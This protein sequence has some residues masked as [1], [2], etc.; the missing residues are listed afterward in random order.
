MKLRSLIFWIVLPGALSA[1]PYVQ[2]PGYCYPPG[3]P[4]VDEGSLQTLQIT[5]GQEYTRYFNEAQKY[6]FCLDETK[7]LF[8]QEVQTYLE[9]Y[10][11][12]IQD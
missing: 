6:M 1:Q 3:P 10:T 5:R 11:E 4:L 2:M 7:K 8:S 12:T 9:Q